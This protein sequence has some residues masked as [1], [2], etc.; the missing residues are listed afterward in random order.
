MQFSAFSKVMGQGLLSSIG[1]SLLFGGLSLSAKALPV[2]R[3][4]DYV[5]TPLGGTF[6]NLTT[7][8]GPVSVNFVGLPIGTP[9]GPY[10]P[11]LPPPPPLPPDPEIPYTA[12]NGGNGNSVMTPT[13]V[14]L[15]D[16]VVNRL[17]DVVDPGFDNGS[18]IV[19]QSTEIEIVGLSLQSFK[20]VIIGGTS[21]DVFA[22]LQKYYGDSSG[23]GTKSMG[24]MTILDDT[25]NG[26]GKK[27]SSN[28]NIN[29]VALLAPAGT[30]T[31]TGNDFIRKTIQEITDP[32]GVA[33]TLYPCTSGTLTLQ[34]YIFEMG[35]FVATDE[36]WFSTPGPNVLLGAN[37]TDPKYPN[38]D[39]YMGLD[40]LPPGTPTQSFY[41]DN[42]KIIIHDA[43]L[44][45]SHI[46]RT[47]GP[48]P[49]LGVSSA[50][51]FTR[52][53]KKRCRQARPVS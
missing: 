4:T 46:V 11:P 53:L 25:I 23:G 9:V 31:P 43:G 33:D 10:L 29:G 6:Y 22:G 42:T 12:P 48:L 40:L 32:K 38:Q 5:T 34:C 13:A 8:A 17:Q 36:P 49:L 44:D 47:P 20:P 24:S 28:F 26:G 52:R 30:V 37:L 39:P 3:G 15:A 1:V 14:G 21:Y 35:P 16:T 51:A 27:W 50:F 19:G 7:P 2:A 41:M 45:E 18:G